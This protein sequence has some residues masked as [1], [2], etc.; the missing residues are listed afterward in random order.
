MAVSGSLRLPPPT[1]I[2][3]K[4]PLF[5]R[6]LLEVLAVLAAAGG[7]DPTKIQGWNELVAAV[8]QNTEDIASQQNLFGAFQNLYNTQQGQI[9][10]LQQQAQVFSDVGPPGALLGKDTDWYYNRTGAA[11]ARLY[12][13]VLGAWVAQAI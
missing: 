9:T 8:A 12:I 6:W 3:A 13:K 10:G 4:D 5:N 7:I 11:G 1:G 2:A